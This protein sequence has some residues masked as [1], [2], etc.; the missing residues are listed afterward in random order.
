LAQ[1]SRR[2]QPLLH[3]LA[4]RNE[5]AQLTSRKP[6]SPFFSL[7]SLPPQACLSVSSCSSSSL[8]SR[9]PRW[10]PPLPRRL[11]WLEPHVELLINSRGCC[12]LSTQP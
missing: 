6:T 3:S 4:P 9:T 2:S 7:V 1:A 10:S 5:P 11:V 12:R 8:P